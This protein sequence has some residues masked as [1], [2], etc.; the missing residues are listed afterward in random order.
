MYN[1]I[2]KLNNLNIKIYKKF[3]PEYIL[4][5]I[6]YLKKNV[7]KHLN[8]LKSKKTATVYLNRLSLQHPYD[9]T[10]LK[11]IEC[12]RFRRLRK[13]V[14]AIKKAK[15]KNLKTNKVL[16][17]N[18]GISFST[19]DSEVSFNDYG[20]RSVQKSRK[21]FPFSLRSSKTRKN[22]TL[23][24]YTSSFGFFIEEED[25]Q[26]L[27]DTQGID[28]NVRFVLE[29]VEDKGL[30]E[31]DCQKLAEKVLNDIFCDSKTKFYDLYSG[32]P[33]KILEFL[34]S[35]VPDDN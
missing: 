16:F 4:Y 21:V 25:F 12:K 8:F 11:K 32:D 9:S 23:S 34:K 13:H 33:V 27:E 6:N 30:S 18:A 1:Y 35:M 10:R 2:K 26:E 15:V 20:K 31:A 14:A 24:S 22:P 28:K 17:G 5:I 29:S 3:K 7:N 19:S